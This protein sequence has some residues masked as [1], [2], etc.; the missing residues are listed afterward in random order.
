[1]KFQQAKWDEALLFERSR[2]GAIGYSFPSVSKTVQQALPKPLSALPKELR[3]SAPP[4]LPEL[5]EPEVMQHFIRLSQMNYC[6]DLGLYPLGSCT[7]KYN[8]PMNEEVIKNPQFS[9]LHPHQDCSTLQGILHIFY[10]LQQWLSEITG[11]DE[12]SLQPAAGAQGELT[13]VLIIRAYHADQGNLESRREIIIPDSAH[14]TNPASAAMAGFDVVVVPSNDQGQVDLKALERA[15]SDKTAGLMLT[16]PNTLG[17]FEQNIEKIAEI[18][19]KAGGL[20]YYDG[21]N[22]NANLGRV[23]PGDMGFDIIHTNLHKTFATP[24]GGGGPGA[25]PVGVKA[26]LASYLPIPVIVFDGENYSLD[27]ERPKSIGRTHGF[28]GNAAVL[29]KAYAY[30]MRMG[31]QGLHAVSDH[32]VLNANYIMKK[33]QGIKGFSVPYAPGVWRKHEVVVSAQQLEQDTGVNAR[34][35]AKALLDRGL[36]APTFYFPAIVEEALMI[37]PTETFGKAELDRFIEAFREISEQAYTN[38][39]VVCKTPQNT[40]IDRL[41]EV[42]AAHPRTMAL[43]WRMF[44]QSQK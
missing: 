2:R 37:E 21:A 8:P 22:L 29:L 20:L 13:G 25:G 44:Q 33:I 34:D 28:L 26:S 14:G 3:R 16:N 30:I 31:W 7:M 40:A 24:H 12:F 42:K 19:H 17:L 32:A 5:S 39:D 1:M 10:E 27:I 18:V 36:H 43:T 35:V 15:V 11:M 4:E 6:V 38:V 41:D 23:R 9:L